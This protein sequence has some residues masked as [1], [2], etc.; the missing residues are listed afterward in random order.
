MRLKEK[1]ERRHVHC[2][3]LANV[4]YGIQKHTVERVCQECDLRQEGRLTPE[5]YDSLPASWVHLADV[6]WRPC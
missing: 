5:L 4:E 1:Y 3:K 6:E 2:W